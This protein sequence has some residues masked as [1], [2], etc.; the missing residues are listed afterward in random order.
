MPIGLSLGAGGG[1]GGAVDSVFGRTGDISAN[2]NDYAA[3]YKA[4]IDEAQIVYVGK[5]GNDSNNGAS[6]EKAFLTIGS[7]ITKAVSLSPSSSN[8]I[9]IHITDAGTYSENISVPSWCGVIGIGAVAV[10]NHTVTD[11]SALWFYRLNSTSGTC[12]SKS[13]GAGSALVR[14]EI[15]NLTNDANGTL[16]TSGKIVFEGGIIY[17]ENGFGFGSTSSEDQVVVVEAISISGTGIGAGVSGAGEMCIQSNCIVDSGSGTGLQTIGTSIVNAV[18]NIIECN[19]VY[20]EGS[21]TSIN[22]I[23]TKNDGAKV[24]NGNGNIVLSDNVALLDNATFTAFPVTPSSVP[25]TDYQV[26]N[27][28]YVDDTV[29]PVSE[30][31]TKTGSNCLT[32][33]GTDNYISVNPDTDFEFGTGDFSLFLHVNFDTI[34]AGRNNFIEQSGTNQRALQFEYNSTENRIRLGLPEDKTSG[35]SWSYA[36][37]TIT[38]STATDYYIAVYRKSGTTYLYINGTLIDSTAGLNGVDQDTGST[39]PIAIGALYVDASNQFYHIDGKMW[40]VGI[41][42][43]VLSTADETAIQ[44]GNVPSNNNLSLFLPLAE[45]SGSVAY[46]TSD[47]DHNGTI[48][49]TLTNVWDNTQDDFH[50]NNDYGFSK[51]MELDGA[52]QVNLGASADFQFGTGDFSFDFYGRFPSN[53]DSAGGIF[54]TEQD[55]NNKQMLFRLASPGVISVSRKLSGSWATI[56]GSTSIIDNKIHHIAMIK[57]G[58]TGNPIKF[59]VD[60][61]EESLSVVGTPTGDWGDNRASIIGIAYTHYI[62]GNIVNLRITKG[63]LSAEEETNIIAGST[64]DPSVTVAKWTGYGNTDADWEDTVGSN[65]GTVVGSPIVVSYPALTDLSLDVIGGEIQHPEENGGKLSNGAETTVGIV[66]TMEGYRYDFSKANVT[67]LNNYPLLPET[68]PTVPFQV[69]SKKYVDD[70]SVLWDYATN[71]ATGNCILLSSATGCIKT[72]NVVYD[73]IG[74]DDFSIN[75]LVKRNGE[76]RGCIFAWGSAT[77]SDRNSLQI[78]IDELNDNL[79]FAVTKNIG[80]V[81]QYLSSFEIVTNDNDGKILNN[82]NWY[83]CAVFRKNRTFYMYVNGVSVPYTNKYSSDLE[84]V[85]IEA[86]DY[87]WTIGQSEHGILQMEGYVSGIQFTA[88]S[89]VDEDLQRVIN[90]DPI[91]E[92]GKVISSYPLAEGA[93][94]IVYESSGNGKSGYITIAFTSAWGNTQD[95][96]FY[97][98]DKGFSDRLFFDGSTNYVTLP[99]G[100]GIGSTFILGA[101]FLMTDTAGSRKILNF[102]PSGGDQNEIRLEIASGKLKLTAIDASGSGG[103]TYK[104]YTCNTEVQKGLPYKVLMVWDGTDLKGYLK[105]ADNEYYEDVPYVKG[106]DGSLSMTDTTRVRRLGASTSNADKFKGLISDIFAVEYSLDNLNKIF[107]G[108]ELTSYSRRWRLDEVS[109]IYIEDSSGNNDD[110]VF[111][112]TMYVSKVPALLNGLTDASYNEIEYPALANGAIGNNSETT[113][114]T[115]RIN[116]KYSF[117]SIELTDSTKSFKPNSGTTTQ[118]NALTGMTGGEEYYDTDRNAK[119][120]YDNSLSS[121]VE[122]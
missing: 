79:R 78:D 56:T 103:N 92:F 70:N 106:M 74:T 90:C 43:D 58:N 41:T 14:S 81:R 29:L 85:S 19:T 45:G 50:Y 117:K 39:A 87:G 66:V 22:L 61:V 121:W 108:E 94:G 26:S 32:L 95:N 76:N 71:K 80:G 57:K 52:D 63:T 102:R 20:N 55:V 7:A 113:V 28:K 68:N 49:G 104:Q 122:V 31:V 72:P 6:I 120:I 47:N 98:N 83:K 15:M 38:L 27:K 116:D 51:Y 73:K 21:G 64:T 99:D 77:D 109:G 84:N 110:G 48:N 105:E 35:S 13:S 59:Y 36:D 101:S 42:K 111:Q 5:H 37:F 107:S 16:C 65:D 34:K 17:V 97:N 2:A 112:G 23:C 114:A 30:A 11:D 75:F 62:K 24:K 118:L 115:V 8:R 89:L 9:L 12:V 93:G 54:S 10:G 82:G 88:G 4:L 96:Y 33:N 18:V 1:G 60:G 40:G 69:A 3:Y 44:Q 25:T 91:N 53:V 100:G 67:E 86:F 46:D 119:F